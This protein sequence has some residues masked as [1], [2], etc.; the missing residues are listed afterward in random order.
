[1]PTTILLVDDFDP[2][3]QYV[4]TLLHEQS[5]FQVVAE[6]RDGFAAIR[7]SAELKPDIV[8][9]DLNLP[10]LSGIVVAQ[11]IRKVAPQTR[12][13]F[14]SQIESPEIIQEAFRLGA[15]AYLLK[16]EA[17]CELLPALSSVSHGVKCVNKIGHASRKAR[18]SMSD[19]ELLIAARRYGMRPS[20]GC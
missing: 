18:P 7:K 15:W 17:A 2:F 19:E 5:A 16:S 4:R 1:M 9:L 14:L 20:S 3:R 12:V 6:A 10:L 8:L 11:Q 13:V